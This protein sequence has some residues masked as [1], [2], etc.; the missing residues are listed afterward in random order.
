[1]DRRPE[2]TLADL[3]R[4]EDHGATWRTLELSDSRAVLELCTCYGEPVDVVEGTRRELIEFVR[5]QG[6]AS[7]R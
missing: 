1:M 5:A 4:W 3:E 2:I 7:A 6:S